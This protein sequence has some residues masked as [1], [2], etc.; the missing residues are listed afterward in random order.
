ML[1]T[2]FVLMQPTE[3]VASS[4][5]G[6]AGAATLQAEIYRPL[7]NALADQMYEAKTMQ[8][9]LDAVSPMAYDDLEQ[10]IAIL[11]SMGAVAPCQSEAA[12]ARV[13]ERCAAF[14]L[15][16]CKRALFN[17]D[18]QVLSSPVTGGGVTVSRFQQL[19][20]IAIRQGKQHPAEWAQLAWSVIAEQNEVLVKDGKT[21]TTAEANIAALTEQAQAFAEQSLIV[22]SALKIV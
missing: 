2:R 13:Y 11:V 4:V 19:F 14:N 9:L 7:L 17:A 10:A 22:L 20:L 8:Q 15:Q 5:T 1:N 16:L 3:N 21:L 6:P 12:E 18:I